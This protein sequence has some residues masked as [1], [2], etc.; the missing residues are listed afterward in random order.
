MW[1]PLCPLSHQAPTSRSRQIFC[2]SRLCK[3]NIYSLQQTIN[4]SCKQPTLRMT[5]NSS[6]SRSPNSQ[7]KIGRSPILKKIKNKFTRKTVM[8]LPLNCKKS[9]KTFW[10]IRDSL[11]SRT[12][13]RLSF[14]VATT[15]PTATPFSSNLL[16]QI[17]FRKN[18]VSHNHLHARTKITRLTIS[19]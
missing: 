4:N 3:G 14:Q 6:S 9:V 17:R 13:N 12:W 18:S 15:L 11:R 1:I 7:N 16:S 2:P 10:L 19:L 5:A 8:S